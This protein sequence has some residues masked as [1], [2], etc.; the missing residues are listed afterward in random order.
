[1]WPV[2]NFQFPHILISFDTWTMKPNFLHL[3]LFF[4][5]TELCLT[6]IEKLC[7]MAFFGF[8][9]RILFS[10]FKEPHKCPSQALN[11]FTADTNIWYFL[12]YTNTEMHFC[13]AVKS[14]VQKV[15]I[16]LRELIFLDAFMKE[17]NLPQK[18]RIDQYIFSIML[19]SKSTFK[20]PGCKELRMYIY[21]E[22]WSFWQRILNTLPYLLVHLKWLYVYFTI[23]II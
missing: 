7:R 11:C 6:T 1:M 23:W 18:Q 16:S 9:Y 13:G 22:I 21:D 19:I 3:F 15:L 4:F 5:F 12:T 2:V 20:Q 14:Q 17:Y 8:F 10:L